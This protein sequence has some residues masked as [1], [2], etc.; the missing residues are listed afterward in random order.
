[1]DE[2]ISTA[3]LFCWNP[4]KKLPTLSFLLVPLKT[5]SYQLSA[6]DTHP[7]REGGWGGGRNSELFFFNIAILIG[8]PSGSLCGGERDRNKNG[9]PLFKQTDT[10]NTKT[11]TSLLR[12]R[13]PERWNPLCIRSVVLSHIQHKTIAPFFLKSLL[14]FLESFV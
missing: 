7:Q 5:D 12:S 1:M 11:K 8:I 3:S 10:Q 9:T 2:Q 4:L 14:L 13:N 6:K